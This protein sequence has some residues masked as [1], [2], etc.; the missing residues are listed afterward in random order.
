MPLQ[1][2]ITFAN[3]IDENQSENINPL[4]SLHGLDQRQT[5]K[6]PAIDGSPFTLSAVCLQMAHP[7]I[8]NPPVVTTYSPR[9]SSPL[10]PCP[11]L[12]PGWPIFPPS[13]RKSDLYRQALKKSARQ[14][15]KHIHRMERNK[16]Q[17]HRNEESFSTEFRG[18]LESSSAGINQ[19]PQREATFN[20]IPES[21]TKPAVLQVHDTEMDRRMVIDGNEEGNIG[22]GTEDLQEGS[23]PMNSTNNGL[24][25]NMTTFPRD[26]EQDG[27]DKTQANDHE[28][29]TLDDLEES[30]LPEPGSLEDISCQ[31]PLDSVPLAAPHDPMFPEE[32]PNAA[33]YGDIDLNELSALAKLDHIKQAME[34]IRALEE[35]SLDDG[36]SKL[37]AEALHCLQNPP[38][39]PADITSQDLC[40]GLDLFLSTINSSQQTYTSVRRA[41]LQCHPNNDIP[42]YDQ[43]KR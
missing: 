8:F 27:T 31:A 35:A 38:T 34:F 6:D 20:N 32:I 13:V 3:L 39:C 12:L 10:G 29:P 21:K 40:L 2:T 41:I 17:K 14:A 1:R 26:P 22:T 36:V 11:Y 25:K 9:Q 37:D 24:T 33:Q 5:K 42:T 28:T 43:M 23:Q 15:K 4:E 18:F 7:S 19:D 16:H 30:Q